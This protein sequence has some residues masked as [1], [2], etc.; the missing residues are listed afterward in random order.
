MATGS[1]TTHAEPATTATTITKTDLEGLR[2][3]IKNMKLEILDTMGTLLKSITEKL[4]EIKTTLSTSFKYC[5]CC[6]GD[7]IADA[8]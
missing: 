2:D 5:R 4:E 8:E 1:Q 7:R 3:S 6:N